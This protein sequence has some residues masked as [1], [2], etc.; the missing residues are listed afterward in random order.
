VLGDIR[1]QQAAP[2]LIDILESNENSLQK[3]A[4]SSLEKIGTPEA[5]AGLMKASE[6]SDASIRKISLKALEKINKT[7]YSHVKVFTETKPSG[8][9][10]LIKSYSRKENPKIYIEIPDSFKTDI[11][12]L[13]N[14]KP[15]ISFE[16]KKKLKNLQ[17]IDPEEKNSGE[18]KGPEISCPYCFEKFNFPVESGE[19]IFCPFCGMKLKNKLKTQQEI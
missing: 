19:P 9:I 5:V 1:A 17:N 18:K 7:D 15:R 3:V 8:T 12:F 13:E 11:S 16:Q 14:S 4:V 6:S 2:A 10:Q